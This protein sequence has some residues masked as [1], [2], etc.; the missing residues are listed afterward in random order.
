MDGARGSMRHWAG[1]SRRAC[2]VSEN[3]AKMRF[4]ALCLSAGN[5]K[6]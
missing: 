6:Q 4:E 1:V 3:R 5:E 2:I